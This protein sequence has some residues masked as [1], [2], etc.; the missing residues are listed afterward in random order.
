MN[1]SVSFSLLLTFRALHPVIFENLGILLLSIFRL[2][3]NSELKLQWQSGI[4]HSENNKDLKGQGHLETKKDW[5][6][7]SWYHLAS[8]TLLAPPSDQPKRSRAQQD[9]RSS[10]M[11]RDSETFKASHM[12]NIQMTKDFCM[13][14]YSTLLSWNR[15]IQM[16][17]IVTRGGICPFRTPPR[18]PLPFSSSWRKEGYVGVPFFV[19]SNSL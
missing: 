6:A 15:K 10:A 12:L 4:V 18:A 1:L 8:E 9:C 11:H 16:K 7:G 2:L 13:A 17:M 19:C 5:L 3:K 14:F